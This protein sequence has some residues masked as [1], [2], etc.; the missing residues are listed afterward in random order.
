M[1]EADVQGYG[2][3]AGSCVRSVPQI[4]RMSKNK[5]CAAQIADSAQGVSL[6]SNVAELIAYTINVAYNLQWGELSLCMLQ[7]L[8][9]LITN[10]TII[11]IL[12]IHC[13]EILQPSCVHT[14]AVTH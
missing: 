12:Y 1:R 10:I 8:G 14:E 6:T 4:M 3:L 7:R 11:S 13:S 5:R 2:V 9:L